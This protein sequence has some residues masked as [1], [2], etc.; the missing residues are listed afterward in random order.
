MVEKVLREKQKKYKKRH[1]FLCDINIFAIS[2]AFQP[3]D[4]INYC[5]AIFAM[6]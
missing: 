5:I 1:I 4:S 2:S 6:Q 3:W